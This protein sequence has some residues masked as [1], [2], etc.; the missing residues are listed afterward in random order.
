MTKTEWK[1]K[2]TDEF[3]DGMRQTCDP[4]ADAV[5]SAMQRQRPSAMLD[6]VEARAKSEAGVFQAYLDQL[7]KVPEWVDWS[8][9]EK[10][11]RV[12][13]GFGEVR[14]LALM[15]S[16]LLEGYSLSKASH[17]LFATGR[18]RQD[19]SRRLYE[20]TQLWHNMSVRDSLRPGQQGHRMIMEVRLLHA[21][22]RKHLKH[23]GWDVKTYDEPINQEDM[24]FTIVQFDY[25]AVRG[26][27]RMGASL[28]EED[29]AALHHLWRYVAYLNGVTE[30]IITLSPAE[31]IYLYDRIRARNYQPTEESRMLTATVLQ[32]LAQQ[33]PFHFPAELFY[34]VSR[35]CLGDELADAYLLPRH[36]GWN[37]FVRTYRMFNRVATIAH[38]HLPGVDRVCEFINFRSLRRK[39][40]KNLQADEDQRTFRHIA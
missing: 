37:R 39:L 28:S 15:A 33:P 34:E 9:I 8:L 27:E 12:N 10:A 5:A 38:Y 4:L 26:M 1:E 13:L 18:L 32:S 14:N 25:L 3:L 21:M 22:V 31:E 36:A 40:R 19:V 7:H 16:S 29:R 23:H 20:T 11:R 24:A 30:A 35:L 17:V 6:E 2:Y